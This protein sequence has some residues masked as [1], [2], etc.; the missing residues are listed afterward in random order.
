VK[1][2]RRA[3]AVTATR[4]GGRGEGRRTRRGDG[5]RKVVGHPR[6][7]LGLGMAAPNGDGGLAIHPCGAIEAPTVQH[8]PAFGEADWE[9]RCRAFP[10]R[11]RGPV[12]R[13]AK[14]VARVQPAQDPDA[15]R[16]TPVDQAFMVR[17]GEADRLTPPVD[18]DGAGALWMHEMRAERRCYSTCARDSQGF[19]LTRGR[20]G[21]WH[22]LALRCAAWQRITLAPVCPCTVAE[23]R[24]EAARHRDERCLPSVPSRIGGRAGIG[25]LWE[26]RREAPQHPDWA[27]GEQPDEEGPGRVEVS[28]PRRPT[29]LPCGNNG[30]ARPCGG[31]I[32]WDD[33]ESRPPLPGRKG[34]YSRSSRRRPGSGRARRGALHS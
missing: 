28:D 23:Q 5:K 11:A 4:G 1:G 30:C 31:T 2:S 34:S 9:V 14:R 7:E 18:V 8:A 27:E 20:G 21:E 26:G 13:A 12:V 10:T 24:S 32:R 22:D 17:L 16:T 19:G 29:R 3:T 15:D 6:A 25:A 33:R